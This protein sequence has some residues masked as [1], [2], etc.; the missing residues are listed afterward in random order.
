MMKSFLFI[1]TPGRIMLL[2]CFYLSSCN[3]YNFSI[4]QPVDQPDLPVF[5]QA[6]LGKW[7]ED[8]FHSNFEMDINTRGLAGYLPVKR[9]PTDD[10]TYQVFQT[11]IQVVFREQVRVTSGAW[12]RL[13]K[14]GNFIYPPIGTRSFYT[15]KEI[16]YDSLKRPVDTTDN[17]VIRRGKIYEVAEHHFLEKGYSFYYDKDTIVIRKNDTLYLELGQNVKLKKLSDSLYALNILK[18]IIGSETDDAWWMMLLLEINP[19]GDITE[20]DITYRAA[21]LPEMIYDRSSKSDYLYFDAAWDKE[22][23]LR[24][25]KNGYF[26]PAGTLIPVQ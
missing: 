12:P 24:L 17:Y 3:V 15:E 20:W 7:K 8:T 13:D 10:W 25:K 21:E 26:Q 1:R 23:I 14:E 19:N 6:F 22:Q 16:N 2:C 5:P 11:Y 18:A 4:P 9:T